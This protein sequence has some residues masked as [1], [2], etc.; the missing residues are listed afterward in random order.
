[1]ARIL[2]PA[3]Y[4]RWELYRLLSEPIRL[5]ILGLASEEELAIGELSELLGESQPTVSKQLKPLRKAGLVTVRKEGTRVYAR[6]AEGAEGDPVIADGVGAGRAL[7]AEDGS[8]RRVGAIVGARDAEGRLFFEARPVEEPVL[9]P[10]ELPAYLTALGGLLPR[11]RLAIDVGTG[12]GS[13][14]EA[15]A[16]AFERVH[17]IDR[18]G[19]QLERA[20]IRLA[21]RGYG[22]VTL[23]QADYTDPAFT[24]RVV[25]EGGADAVF[26]A[27]VLHHA[28]QPARAVSALAA[29]LAPGGALV[30]LDYLAHHDEAL[31]KQ[32]ADLWLGFDPDTLRR[33]TTRAG[34][35]A[36]EAR[37]VPAVRCGAGPDGHLDWLAFIAHRPRS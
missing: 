30:I 35:E 24:E 15:L 18:A 19:G 26:A 9:L 2:E 23:E 25:A 5:R 17:A 8:L 12:D 4:T 34:L 13:L 6:L 28:P 10:L 20:R 37:V 27:R 16:P 32:Q 14:P 29:L 31:R 7:C 36:F 3:A 22:H 21:R 1:V 33:A 11:R